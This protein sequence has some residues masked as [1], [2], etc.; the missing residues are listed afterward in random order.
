MRFWCIA[1]CMFSLLI[2]GCTKS[3]NL[4]KEEEK[5][6]KTHIVDWAPGDNY[7]PFVYIEQ[8]LP[9]G[10]AVDYLNLI[11]EKTG[12]KISVKRAGQLEDILS[13]LEDQKIDLLAAIR[14]TPERAV[15]ASF[16]RPFVYVDLVQV[17][18][19]SVPKT[20]G[21]GSGYA[22][23]NFLEVERKDLFLLKFDNDEESLKALIDGKVDSIV[24]DAYAAK[25]LMKKYNVEFDE[26]RIPF[27]YPLSF[28]VKKDDTVLRSIIDK[29]L[30]S[31]TPEEHARIREKWM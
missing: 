1:L 31:I 22:V 30:T 24:L 26:I 20:A 8:G 9:K 12:L 13:L 29:A 11:S 21:V 10:L 17:R 19:V 18:R 25:T 3:V 27:E 7:Q 16:S 5:Y 4:T 23:V 15:Y 6:I 14:T 28:A 2:V